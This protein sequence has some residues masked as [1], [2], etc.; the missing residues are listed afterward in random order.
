MV[1]D[2]IVVLENCHRHMQ[3]GLNAMSAAIIGTN[4]IVFAIVAMTITLAAVYA[5]MGFVNGFTGKLFFN[6]A[7]PLR[8]ASY[9]QASLH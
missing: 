6:S 1:D 4:E 7:Q 9:Y 5:P 3:T 2:A 8:Y